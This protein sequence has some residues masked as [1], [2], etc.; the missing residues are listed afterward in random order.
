MTLGIEIGS[1][2]DNPNTP[3]EWADIPEPVQPTELLETAVVGF[4]R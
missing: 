1:L 3:C 4:L 2:G